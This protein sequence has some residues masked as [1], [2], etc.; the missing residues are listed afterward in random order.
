[1]VRGTYSSSGKAH[2]PGRVQSNK[3]CEESNDAGEPLF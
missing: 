3:P 2:K 1:M